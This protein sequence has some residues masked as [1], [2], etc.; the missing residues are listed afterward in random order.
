[1]KALLDTN[2]IIHRESSNKIINRE[3]GSLFKWLERT[4]YEKCIHKINLEELNKNSNSDTVNV[5]NIKSKNY[6][7]LMTQA[8]LNKKLLEIYEKFDKTENDKND[9]LLLNELVNDR[10]DIFITEDKKIHQKA[11]L[12]NIDNKVFTIDSFLEKVIAENPELIDYKV[13]SVQKKYFG[14]IDLEDSFFDSLKEDYIGFDKWFNK[15][16]NEIAYVTYRD[17]KLLSFLYLKVEDKDENY[18]D[19]IPAFSPKKRL[20][21]GTFKVEHNGVKLGERFIKIIFDNAIAN[22]VDEIYVTIFDKREGQKRLINLF[23][24]YGFVKWGKKG[25]NGEL[26]YIRDFS[27]NFNIEEPKYTYPFFSTDTDI[28]LVPIYPDYHTNL[29][30]D[31]YLKTESADNFKDDLPHRNAISKVYISR[32]LNKDIK[33]GDIIIFYRT[34]EYG[35]PAKYS[36]VITTIGIVEEKIDN[37]QNEKEFIINSRKRSIFTDKELSSFW[38][39]SNTK[40]FLIN[41]LYVY[42]FKIGDRMNRDK[43]LQLGILTGADN[44]IRGLKQ[45]TKE[46]FLLILKECKVNE[47]FIVY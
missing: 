29:L 46:Q 28:F 41:F 22:K 45:I 14:D 19:I 12:I 38:N 7:V 5:M 33:R 34:K 32:S 37:I 8:P 20:K 27:K 2:I 36:S 35:K 47:S 31:S 40:P 42:S 17:K 4:K 10:V 9:T 16:S 43:L 1:M 21:I 11:K 13:L 30:P 26:V 6:T 18:T 23:E 3:I 24:E 39:F 44:E 15:K 25:E